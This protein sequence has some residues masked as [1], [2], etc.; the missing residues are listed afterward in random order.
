M[1]I[2]LL[3]DI[4]IILGI[5]VIIN[6]IFQKLR[7]PNII[8]FLVTG[9]I[10]GPYG[11][12]LI[13]AIHEVEVMSEIGVVFLLFVIGIEFSLK[14]LAS[15]KK[16][17]ILGGLL[18]VGGT[19]ALVS[20]I[21]KF[22]NFNWNEAVFIG[23]L[24]SLS[25]T[26]IVL[27]TLQSSGEISTPHGRISVALLIFQDI[28][29]VPMILI[30]PILSGDTDNVLMSLVTLVLKL[31]AFGVF[32]YILARFLAP[33]IL[34]QV[35]QTRNRELFIL[36]TIVLCFATAWLT[37]LLGL[38]LALGAFFAGLIISE[39]EF[40]HQ[41]TVNIMP[42][43]E[44]FL[45]FFFV[46]IGMLL[47]L[48]F[49]WNN[50]WMIMALTIV[51]SLLKSGVILVAV[52]AL[53]YPIKTAAQSSLSLFQVGEFAFILSSS[54]LTYG[55]LDG[56]IYQFFLAASIL[57]MAITPFIINRSERTAGYV[58]H[59]Y[60]PKSW[61]KTKAPSN[62]ETN[63]IPENELQ[64]HIV[65]VGYGINGKNVANAA[66]RANLPF[67]IIE[68]NPKN[69]GDAKASGGHV[70][71][72]DASHELILRE[73]IIY[74]AR[75][76]VIAISD[77]N[78]AKKIISQIRM[79]CDTVYVIVRAR[80]VQE[81]ENLLKL[82]ANE[83]IPEEFETSI[84][85]FTRVLNRY[86]VPEDKIQSF[87]YDVR[88]NNYNALREPESLPSNLGR[89]TIR[90]IPEAAL[91]TL[92]AEQGQNKVVGKSVADAR[93]R[94]EYDINIL[95]IKRNKEFITKI[96]PD[97]VIRQDDELFLFGKPD[98]ISRLNAHLKL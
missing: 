12:S 27:N 73:A 81:T 20:V 58:T 63:P 32:I 13:H 14:S 78:T 90:N 51:I 34:S 37:S 49:L 41:A 92:K 76:A 71:F 64:D 59:N 61:D 53:G 66:K 85:I 36:S 75:V 62:V 98:D 8:G 60:L 7:F 87:I 89:P 54:G 33:L 70:I 97:E 2:P 19:I 42:F 74:K 80:F 91:I 18:Q 22:F 16:T 17:V 96:M 25:S 67:V 3:Q 82:G 6:I 84:E 39:S 47:D 95:A 57:S 11:L 28:I 44:I 15:L 9:A 79:L 52:R 50:L 26:A 77:A 68:L 21:L 30:T 43:H 10:A 83:V 1:E 24:F 29:V 65:I 86:L 4:V 5:S 56:N 88:S 94:E 31:V 23:F 93:L 46:S 40:K 69:I 38:S 48:S 35:V 45:S 72:G 55:L